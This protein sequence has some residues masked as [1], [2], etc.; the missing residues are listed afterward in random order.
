MWWCRSEEEQFV[1]EMQ[2]N[3]AAYDCNGPVQTIVDLA[4]GKQVTNCSPAEL[5]ARVVEVIE[6]AY[7]SAVTHKPAIVQG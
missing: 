4:L 6:M 2:P 3:E 1:L 5:G 7:A